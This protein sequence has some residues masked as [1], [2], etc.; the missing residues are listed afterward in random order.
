MCLKVMAH[1]KVWYVNADKWGRIEASQRPVY[2]DEVCMNSIDF[3]VP[4]SVTAASWID[5]RTQLQARAPERYVI[6][7]I[8]CTEYYAPSDGPPSNYVLDS[9]ND[10]NKRFYY[11]ATTA[12]VRRAP[13]LRRKL[14]V[15]VAL[16]ES[17]GGESQD[18]E[19]PPRSDMRSQWQA[20]ERRLELYL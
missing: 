4:V 15:F 14:I 16:S 18:S 9:F 10:Y 3:E 17:Q 1:N 8:V 6:D 5:L 11:D 19:S 7:K 13:G 2:W 20:L 12:H